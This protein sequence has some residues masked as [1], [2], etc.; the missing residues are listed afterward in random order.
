MKTGLKKTVK[1]LLAQWTTVDRTTFQDLD[2][3]TQN[4]INDV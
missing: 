3:E 1:R 2:F 4:E